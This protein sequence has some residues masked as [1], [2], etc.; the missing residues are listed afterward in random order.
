MFIYR[1]AL[2]SCV[3]SSS[4]YEGLNVPSPNLGEMA[5]RV[6][7]C[8]RLMTCNLV[9]SCLVYG[10]TYAY[11]GQQAQL[12]SGRAEAVVSA[13]CHSRF[14]LRGCSFLSKKM[15]LTDYGE[16]SSTRPALT[17]Q[18]YEL[19]GEYLPPCLIS[20]RSFFDLRA[21][22]RLQSWPVVQALSRGPVLVAACGVAFALSVAVVG[23]GVA[24]HGRKYVDHL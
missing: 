20:W 10:L 11:I 18:A 7:R 6:V 5:R 15:V 16:C 3:T 8:G 13:H 21:A 9:K 2:G 24:L 22:F 4:K 17:W 23:H 12:K 14:T 1:K 19:S